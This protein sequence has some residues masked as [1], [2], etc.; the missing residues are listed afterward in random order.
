MLAVLR[1][2]QFPHPAT[3]EI[4]HLRKSAHTQ[5]G[6][7]DCLRRF[8]LEGGVPEMRTGRAEKPI[9]SASNPSTWGG[10]LWTG[11][12]SHQATKTTPR[13]SR[14]GKRGGY[15]APRRGGDSAL[16]GPLRRMRLGLPR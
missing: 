9:P 14:R 5:V 8:L 15:A 12:R 6:G 1:S 4:V 7:V 16:S 3:C 13:S 10:R 11:G 2:W